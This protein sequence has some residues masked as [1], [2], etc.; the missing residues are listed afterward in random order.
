MA[1][2]KIRSV[3]QTPEIGDTPTLRERIE[4]ILF[5]VVEVLCLL[6]FIDCI[7]ASLYFVRFLNL[8]TK[9]RRFAM[10]GSKDVFNLLD[11]NCWAW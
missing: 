1:K 9:R 8:N 6:L 10:N 4:M 3:D 11:W 2:A 5:V 7:M